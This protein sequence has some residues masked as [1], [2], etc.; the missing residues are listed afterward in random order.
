MGLRLISTL[1]SFGAHKKQAKMQEIQFQ[2]SKINAKYAAHEGNKAMKRRKQMEI[3]ALYRKN[4]VNPMGSM[5][6]IFTT[7]PVFLAI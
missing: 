1:F 2:V 5:S 7:M 4:D 3:M 6:S